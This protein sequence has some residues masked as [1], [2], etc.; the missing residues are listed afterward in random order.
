MCELTIDEYKRSKASIGW[1]LCRKLHLWRA[2]RKVQMWLAQAV[3]LWMVIM[4]LAFCLFAARS[5]S[6]VGGMR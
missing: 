4:F 2:V 5:V 1:K 3:P 6:M